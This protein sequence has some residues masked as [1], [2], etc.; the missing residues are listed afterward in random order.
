MERSGARLYLSF[1]H[2]SFELLVGLAVLIVGIVL[3]VAVAGGMYLI[4]ETVAKAGIPEW[5]LL[6]GV[7]ITI[8]ITWWCGV[9][10]WRLLS[11]RERPGGGL[12]PPWMLYLAGMFVAVGTASSNPANAPDLDARARASIS[13]FVATVIKRGSKQD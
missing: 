6:L 3:A 10:A 9:M 7:G 12:L 2:R 11:G 8:P 4:L 5:S 13:D 1:T